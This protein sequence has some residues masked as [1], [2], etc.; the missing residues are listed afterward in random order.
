LDCCGTEGYGRFH[1]KDRLKFYYQARGSNCE[2]QNFI[3][4]S[5]DLGYL[6]EQDYNDLKS[7][8]YEGYKV[9]NGLIRSTSEL[10]DR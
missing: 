9:L 8:S 3:I 5:K 6:N 4:L 2:V 10:T 7:K 1:F